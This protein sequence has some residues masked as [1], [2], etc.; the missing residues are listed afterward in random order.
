VAEVRIDPRARAFLAFL[1]VMGW[2]R[3]HERTPA[4][5]RRDYRLLA[6]LTSGW[7][8]VACVRDAI[9]RDADRR[10]RVRVYTPLR[11]RAP[12]PLLVYFHGGG[13]VVGDL[14]TVDGLCRGLA[15][16]AGAVVVSVDYRRAPEHPAPAA[17]DDALA[18]T[19]WALRHARR[20]GADPARVAVGGDSAGATLAAMVAQQLRD[21]I[22]LQT[23]IYPATDFTFAQTERDP[24][25]ARLPTWETVD[26]FD[27]HALS[28]ADRRDPR[29]SPAFMEDLADVPRAVI[30]TAAVDSFAGDA[31]RYAERMRAAGVEVTVADFDGQV[32]GFVTMDLI[33]PAARRARR[34]VAGA[35]AGMEPV[36]ARP[37][38][39]A[40]EPIEWSGRRAALGSTAAQLWARNPARMLAQWAATLAQHRLRTAWRRLA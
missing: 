21:E 10:V 26:W 19:R 8:P 16:E 23:L 11:G 32:H 34:L 2:P 7:Q 20:L 27:R 36:R 38:T 4:Q 31:R 14:E 35:V 33:F 15:N 39:A 22:A 5:A 40:P 30:V 6:N 3:M 1:D 18:A 25:L 17:Q 13:F 12:R 37:L 29:V 24:L 28:G 9:A